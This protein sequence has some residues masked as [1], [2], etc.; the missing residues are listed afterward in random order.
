MYLEDLS[1]KKR[2]KFGKDRENHSLRSR[3]YLNACY[4]STKT[5][6]LTSL[7]FN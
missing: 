1:T 7:H 5:K 3:I 6:N 2:P 4:E